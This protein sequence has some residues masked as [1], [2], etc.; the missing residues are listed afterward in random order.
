MKTP[1]LHPDTIDQV[2]DR[3]DIVDV[4]SEHVV[5][6]KQGKDFVGLCPFHDDKSPSFSVSPSKQFYYCFSCGAGGNAIKFLMELG[7]RSFSDVVLDLARRYQVS[8]KTLE[9]TNRQEFQRQLSLREQLYEITALTARFYEHALHQSDGAAALD[10]LRNQRS[11]S[12]TTIQQFQLGYAPGGWQTLYGYL[13]EQ[14]RYPV[15]LVEQAGL[16]VPRQGKSGYY[17]RF[18]DRLMIPIHDLQGRVIG[19]GGRALGEAQPKYLNSPDTELFD[20]GKTL[21]AL[22]KA[23][24]AIA[25]H[26][27]ALVVEGYFD[28]IALHAAGITPAVASLGTAINKGQVKQLLRYT[29]SKQ[30]ILNFDADAAGQKAAERAIDEVTDLAYRGDV[31]LRVLTIPEGKDPDDFLKQHSA[32]DYHALIQDAPLWLDW[33]IQLAF[34]GKDLSQ[35]DHNHQVTQ[36]LVTFLSNISNAGTRTHYVR[37]CAELLSQGDSRLVPLLAETLLA[38]VRRQRRRSPDGAE[39]PRVPAPTLANSTLESAEAVLLRLYLHAPDA[40][41]DILTALDERDLQFS[42]SH[43]R[44]LWRKIL[45]RDGSSM[46]DPE[47]ADPETPESAQSDSTSDLPEPSSRALSDQLQDDLA[48]YPDQL[49]QVIYLF[50]LDEKARRD[51]LRAPIVIQAATDCL[52]RVMCEK[53]YQH[54]RKLWA[55]T[56]VTSEPEL[57]RHYQQ[58]IYAEKQRIKELDEHRSVSFEDLAQIPWVGDFYQALE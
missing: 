12:E 25:K 26:D 11:L 17:D 43:H 24:T 20:K 42:L 13:V 29:E 36:Q 2:K 5:L 38:Q 51:V 32:E 10:Y 9:A 28:V 47:M 56:D 6:R 33:Q 50:Q 37:H 30:V 22:D 46:A 16:I 45:E 14:K 39:M 7:Q 31:Q 49:N 21:F 58:Q 19:F 44:F 52:E 1:R 41:A 27:C 34:V 48:E 54:F 15:H 35:A 3:A 23:R 4:V 55:E 8:V 53:R 18:R 57:C 40:R